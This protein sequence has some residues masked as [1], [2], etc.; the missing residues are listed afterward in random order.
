MVRPRLIVSLAVKGKRRKAGAGGERWERI[1]KDG[2][3]WVCLHVERNRGLY[4]REK[5]RWFEAL[6]WGAR[7][8]DG[9]V[10]GAGRGTG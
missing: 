3:H 8:G 10:E 2:R 5:Y 1:F 9:G 4:Q 7:K 6:E